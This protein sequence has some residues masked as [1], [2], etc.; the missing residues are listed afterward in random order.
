MHD[1]THGPDFVLTT[2]CAG[3]ADETESLLIQGVLGLL[4]WH[5]GQDVFQE[6]RLS[7]R[8]PPRC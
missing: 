6:A 2:V 5:S 4:D 1:S 3:I 8:Q 7:K